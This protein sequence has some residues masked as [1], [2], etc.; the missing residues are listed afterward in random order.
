VL[1]LILLIMF[2]SSQDFTPA[3]RRRLEQAK[4]AKEGVV[5][6]REDIKE[7]V[8]TS[9]R[10]I[11]YKSQRRGIC[12]SRAVPFGAA[13]LAILGSAAMRRGDFAGSIAR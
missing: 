2:L 10:N 12:K 6:H 7:K 8:R 5:K 13:A 9:T 3:S 1:G 4:E 11:M